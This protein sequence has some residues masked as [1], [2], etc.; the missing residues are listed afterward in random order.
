VDI[1]PFHD[2]ESAM[3]DGLQAELDQLKADI[4]SGAVTVNG[5]LGIQ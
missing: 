3:P 4:I 2:F 5:V 1:A